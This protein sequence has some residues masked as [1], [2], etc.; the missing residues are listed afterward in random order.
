MILDT[1]VNFMSAIPPV[2]LINGDTLIWNFTSNTGTTLLNYTVN[3]EMPISIGYS[4]Y[5]Y[6]ETT[7]YDSNNVVINSCTDSVYKT[8]ACSY[9][10]NDKAV[11]PEGAGPQHYTFIDIN[12]YLDY[13]IRFQNTGTD[14][15]FNVVITDELDPHLNISTFELLG[16]SHP[17]AI[18]IINQFVEFSFI[19]ILLP[20]S[21]VD[22]TSSH[23]FVSF[24][25]Y[26]EM[27]VIPYVLQN[28]ANIFFDF[29]PAIV[30]NTVFNTI[31]I[32]VG[33]NEEVNRQNRLTIYPN[34]FSHVTTVKFENDMNDLC[35]LKV[36]DLTGRN[37]STQLTSSDN[38][39][40]ERNG[41]NAGV[42]FITVQNINSNE[43]LHGKLLMR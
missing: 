16:S 28:T 38:F 26:P 22:E 17:V 31:D 41:I 27:P 3:L 40:I 34:P 19:N 10:P 21:N 5:T 7:L 42:Y 1:A 29:N 12:P 18:N 24:R 4:F 39:T 20:D 11:E 37:I 35:T 6:I 30:T 15:A 43:L 36:Y 8:I 9:D 23:G 2:S 32:S 25:C 13:T 14:T 33:V